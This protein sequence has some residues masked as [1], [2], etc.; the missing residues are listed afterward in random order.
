MTMIDMITDKQRFIDVFDYQPVDRVPNWE[1]GCWGQTRERWLAEG[2]SDNNVNWNW[3]YGDDYWGMDHRLFVPIDF[4]MSRPFEHRVVEETDEYEIFIDRDGVKRQAL[5]AGRSRFG[6]RA[7]MDTFLEFPVKNRQDFAAIRKRFELVLDQRYP[8]NWKT[9][10]LPQWQASECPTILGRNTATGGFYW[11][12]RKMMGTEALCYAWYDQPELMHEMM[13]FVADFTIAVATPAVDAMDFEY[14][15]IAED[16]AMKS[17]PLLSPNVYEEFIFPHLKRL[18]EFLKTN[19]V[20]Y[21]MVDTDG[22]SE[23]LFPLLLDAGVDAVWPLE[24]AS[25]DTDPNML[26]KKYGRSL[27]LFGGVD[28]RELAKD[29]KA[30]DDHLAALRPLIEEGGFIPT[31]DHTVPPDVSLDNFRY[32]M[33]RKAALLRGE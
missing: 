19:G 31:V 29:R 15:M 32:Y 23:P 17:G 12:A 16:M 22:N 7:S 24:R 26:R 21:V 3:W 14:V 9:E 30:I 13:E 27:R 6:T 11:R 4:G 1:A 28:K 2:L 10:H 33:E 8:E 20:R 18:V 25:N 5:K